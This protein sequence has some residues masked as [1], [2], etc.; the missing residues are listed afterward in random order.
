LNGRNDAVA[1]ALVTKPAGRPNRS[2]RQE[3]S[4][5]TPP[6]PLA[7]DSGPLRRTRPKLHRSPSRPGAGREGSQAW[8]NLEP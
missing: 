6:N 1:Q 3:R 5:T 8:L 7:H 2:S 4:D